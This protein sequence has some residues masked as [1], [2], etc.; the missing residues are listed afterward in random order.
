MKI[1]RDHLTVIDD[2]LELKAAYTHPGQAHFAE[3]TGLIPAAN[4]L[5]SSLNREMIRGGAAARPRTSP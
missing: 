1:S 4:A 3:P 5:T 2:E